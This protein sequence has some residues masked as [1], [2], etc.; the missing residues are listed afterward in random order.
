MSIEAIQCPKCGGPLS[1]EEGRDSVYCSH[2]GAGLRIST[3]SSGHPLATLDDIKDDTSLLAMRAALER[4][5]E[6]L[7]E[8]DNEI[9]ALED[10]RTSE[11]LDREAEEQR[12]QQRQENRAAK[13]S[14]L[15]SQWL[16]A[17]AGQFVFWPL[18]VFFL[19]LAA[20]AFNWMYADITVEGAFLGY[21]GWSIVGGALSL[22][23]AG[24]LVALAWSGCNDI[25]KNVSL[26]RSAKKD[27]A[28]PGRDSTDQKHKDL[29]QQ[30]DVEIDEIRSQIQ[31]IESQRD[32]L[33]AKLDSLTD[34]L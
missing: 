27:E 21:H 24:F 2:C 8:R 5:D 15:D 12:R 3:G 17:L 34:Q 30:I 4:L 23:L 18:A 16:N 19:Y 31:E 25:R 7:Q 22:A 28:A 9:R 32:T 1:V 11:L 33:R 26:L 20:Y 29:L 6:R 10:A 14:E 13:V